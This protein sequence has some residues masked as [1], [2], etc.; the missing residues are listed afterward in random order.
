MMLTVDKN[1]TFWRGNNLKRLCLILGHYYIL[2][3]N[4]IQLYNYK[5]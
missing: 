4:I 2:K 1:I 5:K 3:S